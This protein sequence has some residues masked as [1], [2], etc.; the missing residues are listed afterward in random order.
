MNQQTQSRNISFL[1]GLTIISACLLSF[2]ILLTRILSAIFYYHFAFFIISMALLGLTFGALIVHIAKKSF[3]AG[4]THNQIYLFSL[5]GT[6]FII[7]SVLGLYWLPA[8]L[9]SKQI[10]SFVMPA[11]LLLITVPF[12]SWGIVFSLIFSRHSKDIARVYC[13]N[14]SGSALGCIGIPLIMNR[15]SSGMSAAFIIAFLGMAACLCFAFYAKKKRRNLLI[16][17][18]MIFAML[19]LFHYNETAIKMKPTWAKEQLRGKECQA[20]TYERWNCFSTVT[21]APTRAP[22]GWGFSP[23]VNELDTRNIEQ[24]ALT[25]DYDAG[26]PLTYFKNFKDLDFLKYDVTSIAYHIRSPKDVVILGAGGGRDLLTAI[27]FGAK[28]VWGVEINGEIRDIALYES[29]KFSEILQSFPQIRY[30][31]DDGR[32]F[33]ARSKDK[34]DLIQASLIDSFAATF[35]GAFSLTENNLYTQ[36]AWATFLEHLKNEGILTYSHW[37]DRENPFIIMRL[38]SLAKESLGTLGIKDARQNIIIIAQKERYQSILPVATLIISKKPF[39]HEEIS[40]LAKICKDLEFE[41]ILSP[42]D[43]KNN[44]FLKILAASGNKAILQA[45]SF[46]ARAPIDNRPFF[47]AFSKLENFFSK[48]NADKGPE[49]LKNLL[50]II[51]LLGATLIILPAFIHFRRHSKSKIHGK[52]SGYFFSIGSGFMLVEIALIQRLG[53]FLGHPILGLTVSLFALLLASGIGSYLTKYIHKNKQ[54]IRIFQVLISLLLLSIFCI[55]MIIKLASPWS[56]P[57]KIMLSVIIM[58]GVGIFMGM[59]FPLG[60]RKIAVPEDELVFYWAVNGF[61]SVFASGIAAM[62]MIYFGFLLTL[63]CGALFYIAAL[64]FYAIPQAKK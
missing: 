33:V 3:P 22:F 9:L 42:E 1:A 51:C 40:V 60:A 50:M 29:G 2:E 30:V 49:I 6:C 44:D 53:I 19:F 45:F 55:P 24:I 11:L 15:L 14:L 17:I 18:T 37:Y 61:A 47:F 39:S 36:E 62:L 59:P 34:F 63:F 10:K 35:N 57:L 7:F 13:A 41:I 8:Y 12:I 26:T 48:D 54:A 16:L 23:K 25:I 21:V 56:I 27:L 31:V 5:L 58:A 46:D 32:S 64:L 43:S 52:W 38:I 20:L 4:E 28:T